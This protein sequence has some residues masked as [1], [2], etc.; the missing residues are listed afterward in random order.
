MGSCQRTT[1]GSKGGKTCGNKARPGERYCAKHSGGKR[2]G[3]SRHS[4]KTS[5]SGNGCGSLL[6]LALTALLLL[7]L[8]ILT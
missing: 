5:G 6:L 8:G 7:A 3:G 1:K 2:P 4:K